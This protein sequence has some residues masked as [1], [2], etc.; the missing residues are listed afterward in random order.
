MGVIDKIGNDTLILN[1]L[2]L[3]FFQGKTPLVFSHGKWLKAVLHHHTSHIM[4]SPECEEILTSMN[5]IIEA[6]TRNYN[7]IL[8]LRGKLE[9]IVKQVN[10]QDEQGEFEIPM[11]FYMIYIW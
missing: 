6:R 11:F 5:T 3:L 2:Y 1:N 10:T 7:K 9:M 4:S 8:Q